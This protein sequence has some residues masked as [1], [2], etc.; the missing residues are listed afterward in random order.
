MKKILVIED[1]KGVRESL[2]NL[3]EK[4]GYT[5]ITAVDGRQGIK[6][7]FELVPDL[8]LCDIMM[9]DTDGY[10]VLEKI[11]SKKETRN[12]PFLFLTARVEA[13]DLRRGMELGADDYIFKPFRAKELL[14]A[15]ET[16]LKKIDTI[17]ADIYDKVPENTKTTEKDNKDFIF[18]TVNNKS[19]FIKI[20]DIKYIGG[21][22]QYTNIGML[23]T[24]VYLVRKSMADWEKKLP[25]EKFV[26]IHRSTIINLNY[27][28]K[29]EK[30][31]NSAY[32]LFLKDETE[33]FIISNRYSKKIKDSF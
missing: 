20:D 30:W 21:Q 17:K 31:F 10:E 25:S 5:V 4:S 2:E 12:I 29:V 11:S 22:N 33:P 18:L 27:V 19:T 32:K 8:I 15:I 7:A 6:L 1:E 24:S 16:R 28:E 14:N 9:P 3:L 13:K 26:R 23:D